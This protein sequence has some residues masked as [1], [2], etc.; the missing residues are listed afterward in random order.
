MWNK[1]KSIFGRV[2]AVFFT[3]A[4]GIVSGAALLAPEVPVWKSALL[5]GFAAVAD[6]LQRLAKA[7][8]DGML[9]FNEIN[10]AFSGSDGVKK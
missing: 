10:E 9:T 1:A 2:V 7:S 6:V 5:A 8:L 3:S 4:L